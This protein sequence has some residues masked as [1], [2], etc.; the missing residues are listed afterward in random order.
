MPIISCDR[1]PL[2]LGRTMHGAIAIKFAAGDYDGAFVADTSVRVEVW[3]PALLDSR[4][5]TVMAATRFV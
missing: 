1:P 4:P 3:K 5:L 2:S